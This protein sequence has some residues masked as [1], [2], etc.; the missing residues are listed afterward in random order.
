MRTLK[1]IARG[2]LA[3]AIG[4][5]LA[6]PALADSNE[7]KVQLKDCPDAVQKTI[8]Q[9]AGEGTIVE[10]EKETK[11]DGTVVYEAD[12]KMADGKKI[13][14]KVAADGK[15]IKVEGEDDAEDNDGD[16]K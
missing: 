3:L 7:E 9:E 16:M 2:L 5:A 13:E 6:I 10:I 14:I 11:K 8:K 1:H 4:L 15:L 12:V